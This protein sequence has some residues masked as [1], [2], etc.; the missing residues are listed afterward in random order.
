MTYS[1]RGL[2]GVPA[3]SGVNGGGTYCGGGNVSGSGLVVQVEVL[4]EHRNVSLTTGAEEQRFS[5]F[6]PALGV[7]AYR[8]HTSPQPVAIDREISPSNLVTNPSFES[9]EGGG[10]V[11]DGLWAIAGQ[12]L[13]SSYFADSYTAVEGRHSLRLHT[14]TAGAGLQLRFFP[15]KTLA[16]TTYVLS[17]WLMAEGVAGG[18]LPTIELGFGSVGHGNVSWSS[19]AARPPGPQIVARGTAEWALHKAS[20][21]P[22]GAHYGTELAMQVVGEG[23]IWIDLLQLVQP[24][25]AG[26]L[27]TDDMATT[28]ASPALWM[29]A[30]NLD[31]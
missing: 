8:I 11:P 28:L 2:R 1:I 24:V 23:V 15:T 7:R 22:G 20:V 14:P 9:Q 4:F 3:S 12:D 6:V 29:T 13:M 31:N 26:G 17:V 21:V 30:S 19:S 27:K 10:L 18:A 16:N 25:T 5:D